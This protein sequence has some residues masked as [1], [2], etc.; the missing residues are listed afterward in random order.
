MRGN[1]V[2]KYLTLAS[3]SSGTCSSKMMITRS[4]RIS[5]LSAIRSCPIQILRQCSVIWNSWRHGTLQTAIRFSVSYVRFLSCTRNFRWEREANNANTC[6]V[7]FVEENSVWTCDAFGFY[8]FRNSRP[9]RNWTG[10]ISI[11]KE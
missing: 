9:K 4:R 11:M 6:F 7:R 10:H 2:W 3:D 5:S 1:S 8:R